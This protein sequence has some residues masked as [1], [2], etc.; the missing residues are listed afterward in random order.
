[1][2]KL[3]NYAENALADFIRG[4]GLTLPGN[5]Y[6][7]LASTADDTGATEVTGTSYARVGVTRSLTEFSGT[8][9]ATTTA[10]STGVS[11]A[12]RNNSAILWP[13]A[14]SG[15]WTAAS[16]LSVWDAS[17]GG[18]CWFY[19]DLPSAVT[20]AN[21]SAYSLAISAV[22]F[23]LGLT[24]GLTDYLANKLIDLIWR[25]QAYT[26]PSTTY[27]R[28]VTTTPTNAIG[29][30]EVTGGS[31]ARQAVASTLA[32]W[33]GTQ[34]A[35]STSAS[36][37]SSGRISN[38]ADVAFPT[39]TANWG[40]VTHAEMLDAVSGG[41]RLVWAPVTPPRTVNSGSLPPSYSP[42]TFGITLA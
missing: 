32:A 10:A 29:G 2:S 27:L 26:W 31:Y 39:P 9:G 5:W 34:A 35:G 37:G 17:T 16:K 40:T 7:S 13:T 18:N 41:N 12:T 33:S 30:V 24:G 6:F 8:Q 28:L 23:E 4:Q 11:H 21:G 38:N 3:T 20:V 25:N 42:N 36:S 15:G 19:M 22:V 1:M 14:G